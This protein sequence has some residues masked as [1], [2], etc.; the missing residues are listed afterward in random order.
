VQT[1]QIATAFQPLVDHPMRFLGGEGPA[2]RFVACRPDD[3]MSIGD[4]QIELL[5]D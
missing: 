2:V 3:A 5:L 1:R 4:D